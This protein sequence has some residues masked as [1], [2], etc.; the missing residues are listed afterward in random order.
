M[1]DEER[2]PPAYIDKNGSLVIPKGRIK[3]H[4]GPGLH[5]E[6]GATIEESQ[7]GGGSVRSTSEG[8][9]VVKRRP[10]R[11]SRRLDQT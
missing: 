10:G 3:K 8:T 5:P 1:T 9:V 7:A 4:T 6:F 2:T 11:P